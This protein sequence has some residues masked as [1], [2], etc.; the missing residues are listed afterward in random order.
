MIQERLPSNH[1]Q[2]SQCQARTNRD[3][4][5]AGVAAVEFAVTAPVFVILIV[6]SISVCKMLTV[7]SIMAQACREGGRLAAMDWTGSLPAGTTANDKVIKDI[8]NFIDA[9]GID[10]ETVEVT[11]TH[12]E[13]SLEGTEFE[14]GDPAN[15]LELFRITAHKP[16]SST[17]IF[18]SHL[19]EGRGM[20]ASIV[21][22]AG[23]S[24]MQQ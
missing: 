6:G 17:D 2:D 1:R 3:R 11:V 7:T 20:T 24:T 4:R 16:H 13:G 23:R 9:A 8:K 21:L 12:A 22:R 5:R 14:L 10:S 15:Y 18:C 19:T